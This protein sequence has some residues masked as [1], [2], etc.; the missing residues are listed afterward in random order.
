MKIRIETYIRET[1]EDLNDVA[2][3]IDDETTRNVIKEIAWYVKNKKTRDKTSLLEDIK[4]HMKERYTTKNKN[5]NKILQKQKQGF[6]EKRKRK[7]IK[8]KLI[9]LLFISLTY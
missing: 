1:A 8:K 9:N 3:N 4:K 2:D 7:K 6:K 5:K